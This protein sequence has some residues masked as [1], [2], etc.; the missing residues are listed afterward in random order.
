[1]KASRIL[2][3]GTAVALLPIAGAFA[4]WRHGNFNRSYAV[5]QILSKPVFISQFLYRNVGSTYQSY[6]NINWFIGSQSGNLP[7][8]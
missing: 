4:Q 8:L 2:I 5:D 7:V 3:V 6:I 1:M